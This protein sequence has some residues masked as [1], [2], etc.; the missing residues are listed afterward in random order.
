MPKFEVGSRQGNGRGGPIGTIEADDY[1][2]AI[3][4]FL[5]LSEVQAAGGAESDYVRQINPTAA[6]DG[7]FF[8]QTTGA[9][10]ATSADNIDDKLPDEIAL[11]DNLSEVTATIIG[12]ALLHWNGSNRERQTG[13]QDLTIY[14]SAART[15]NPTY[16]DQVN[17]NAKGLHCYI[18]CTAKISSPSVVFTIEAKDVLTG[19][20]YTILASAAITD[21]GVTVLKVYPGLTPSANL[22]ANDV[23]PRT[24][25]IKA[26]HANSDSIT[27]SVGVSLIL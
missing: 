16:V 26:V 21:V 12:A 18:K 14:S 22:I 27:Y 13:N 24:W 20:Y 17:R 23:L 1:E 19:D 15:A 3:D 25:R 11:A 6:A 4:D 7:G 2:D 10:L 9:A 5:A 8:T